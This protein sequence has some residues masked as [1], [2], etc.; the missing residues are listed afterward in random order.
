MGQSTLDLRIRPAVVHD[1]STILG[2]IRELAEYEKLD[3]ELTVTEDLLRGHLFGP[4]PAAESLI[5]SVGGRDV[6][7]AVYFTN[8]S[9][10]S[11]RLGIFLEDLYVQRHARGQGVGK[12]LLREVARIALERGCN[13]LG[14]TVLDWNEP[15]IQFYKSLGAV[16]M[17]DWTMFRLGA[18]AMGQLAKG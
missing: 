4:R 11:G 17:S 5:A 8:Y 15:A 7:Y 6:G 13:W 9:T 12:A 3:Q 14:W 1:V 18:E 2:L 16:P 10:F